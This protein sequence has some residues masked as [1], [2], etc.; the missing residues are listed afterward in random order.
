M[1]ITEGGDCIKIYSYTPISGSGFVDSVAFGNFPGSNITKIPSGYS[2]CRLGY[3]LFCKDKSPTMGLPNDTVGTCGILQGHIVDKN[4][5]SV[6]K[7]QFRF[8]DTLALDGSGNYTTKIFA[9][10]VKWDKIEMFIAPFTSKYEYIDTLSMDIDPD[11]VITKDIRFTDYI[12]NVRRDYSAPSGDYEV[13]NYPNPFNSSTT[14]KIKIPGG[15]KINGGSL[16]IVT[17]KGEEV[18]VLPLANSSTVAWD[19]KNSRGVTV[20][21]G[22]YYYR[23]IL[24]NSIHANGSMIFLK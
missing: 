11:T 2:L 3:S 16:H 15:D 20:S 24:D 18:A 7:G 12:V 23:L 9:R 10:K 21:S 17:V 1:S 5:R 14:F 19:G 22:V 13:R 4:N 8:D 6:T